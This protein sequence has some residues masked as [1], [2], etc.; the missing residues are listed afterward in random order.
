MGAILFSLGTNVRSS[1]MDIE[2]QTILLNA[3]KQ[4]P[5]YHF[6]WKFEEQTIDLQLPKNVIVRPWLPQSDILAHPKVR[7][8][9][10]HS[11]NSGK[12][13]R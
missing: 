13:E 9:F 10:T 4:F 6:L 8:L 12:V 2:K 3:F 5:E 11:G 1:L 7:A